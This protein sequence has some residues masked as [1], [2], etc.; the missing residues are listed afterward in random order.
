M[1]KWA[2]EGYTVVAIQASSLKDNILSSAEILK[3]CVDAL[4]SCDL[5]DAKETFGMVGELCVPFAINAD[6]CLSL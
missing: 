3:A 6:L 1:L 5:C 2:E 4:S